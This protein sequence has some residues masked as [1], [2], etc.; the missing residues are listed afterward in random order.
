VFSIGRRPTPWSSRRYVPGVAVL[1]VASLVPTKPE[2]I[3]A[4]VP[5]QPWA[6]DGGDVEV[7][8]AYRFDDPEGRVGLEAH[9]VRSAGA[10]L[11][12][13]LTYRDA[14][15]DGAGDHLVAT[16]AHSVLGERWVY[17]GLHDPIFTRMLAAA[18]MTG[19]GQAVGMVEHG[20]RWVVVPPAVRLAGGGWSDAR[21]PVDRFEVESDEGD[22]AVLRN[23][24]FDLVVGRRLVP[25]DTPP[26]GLTATWPGQPEP[27]VLAE[28]RDRSPG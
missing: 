24:R 2:A 10:L 28:V 6:P 3:A 8:A 12:V 20:E 26:I 13:P 11:H 25:G 22:R 7:V 27:V 14:P 15:L 1:H 9:L 17:D 23:D 18:T 21:V 16:M 4:W 19:C 5:A